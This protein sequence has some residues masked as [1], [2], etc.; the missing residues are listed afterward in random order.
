MWETCNPM[1]M[2]WRW[3]IGRYFDSIHERQGNS[4]LWRVLSL[5]LLSF[6]VEVVR[7]TLVCWPTLPFC[8]WCWNTGR[9]DECPLKG[10]WKAG[11]GREADSD[12]ITSSHG[13]FWLT[14]LRTVPISGLTSKDERRESILAL[15]FDNTELLFWKMGE[16]TFPW[17]QQRRIQQWTLNSWP[18]PQPVPEKG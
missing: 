10:Q 15:E 4:M 13:P 17:G 7:G 8:W 11:L 18:S 3:G 14:S 2:F 16:Q 1:E 6:D 9:L 12:L 5:Q